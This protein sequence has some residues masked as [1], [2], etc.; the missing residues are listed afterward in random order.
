M[1]YSPPGFCTLEKLLQ[2]SLKF[3]PGDRGKK[4]VEKEAAHKYFKLLHFQ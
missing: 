4:A 3:F 1:F 2:S